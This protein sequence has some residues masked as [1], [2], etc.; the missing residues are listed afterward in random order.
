MY[1]CCLRDWLGTLHV[2]HRS[3]PI[4]SSRN[5]SRMVSPN[6]HMKQNEDDFSEYE[7]DESVNIVWILS[8]QRESQSAVH[9]HSFSICR[10]F[11][12]WEH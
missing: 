2:S 9:T 6:L 4:E 7:S 3:S 8:L 10:E 11:Y 1:A 12:M 5:S